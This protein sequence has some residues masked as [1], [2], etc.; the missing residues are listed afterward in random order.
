MT[1]MKKALAIIF[2]L[3]M[4]SPAFAEGYIP[5]QQEV[6][7][8][9]AHSAEDVVSS[10]ISSV[11]YSPEYDPGGVGTLLGQTGPPSSLIKERLNMVTYSSYNNVGDMPITRAI[12]GTATFN[13]DFWPEVANL[14]A[15]KVEGSEFNAA[16]NKANA[17][18]D[19]AIPRAEKA[20]EHAQAIL[21]RIIYPFSIGILAIVFVIQ[22]IATYFSPRTQVSHFAVDLFRFMFFLIAIL[23]FRVWVVLLLDIFNFAGYLISPWGGQS[24]MQKGLVNAAE[25]GGAFSWASLSGIAT[26]I[27]RWAAYMSIKVLFISRDVMLAVS[28]VTGPLCLAMGYLS[29]YT[30]NDFVKGFLSGWLQSFFKFQFWGVFASI[31][32]IGLAIVDFLSKSGSAEPLVVFITGIA[33]VHAAFNIPKLADNMSSVVISS[34]LMATLSMAATRGT[35][36]ATAGAAGVAKSGARRLIGR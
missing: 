36:G 32:L 14:L 22:A 8:P 26:G 19:G 24:E 1:D 30:Q 6:A 17:L 34:V 31:A 5:M 35:G 11:P 21:P 20:A 29:L 33:F 15:E 18:R 16:R 13:L 10:I 25:L 3:L 23:S 12:L 27:M 9:S 4:S 7:Y 2:I 28:L